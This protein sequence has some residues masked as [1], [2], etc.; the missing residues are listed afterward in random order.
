[1][2][3]VRA[4]RDVFDRSASAHWGT[5]LGSWVVDGLGCTA[6]GSAIDSENQIHDQACV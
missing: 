3:I 1:M 2:E 6:Y 5:R 4:T